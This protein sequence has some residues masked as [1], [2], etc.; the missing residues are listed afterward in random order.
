MPDYPLKIYNQLIKLSEKHSFAG[1]EKVSR[2]FRINEL[3]CKQSGLTL[4]E[5]LPPRHMFTNIYP[6][7]FFMETLR[8][9][10]KKPLKLNSVY[11]TPEYNKAIGGV[12]KSA[13]VT[14]RAV[15]IAKPNNINYEWFYK[16]C[17]E[18]AIHLEQIHGLYFRLGKY[19]HR[20]F[21]HI[22]CERSNFR[23]RWGK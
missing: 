12:S 17:D 10:I 18:L 3:K 13:H 9:I 4:D 20:N 21:V 22:D 2:H 16:Q 19:S 23:K 14:F 8:F 7:I 5:A 6:T 15:D 1:Q 11:R